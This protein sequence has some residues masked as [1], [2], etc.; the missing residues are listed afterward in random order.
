MKMVFAALALVIGLTACD[1]RRGQDTGRVSE[2][3]DTTVTTRTAQDT[4]IVRSD[5]TIRADTTVRE[6]EV[7]RDSAKTR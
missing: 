3:V 5:T 6:G 4:M 2:A 1:T 7:R